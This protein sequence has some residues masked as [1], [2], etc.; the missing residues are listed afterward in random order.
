MSLREDERSDFNHAIIGPLDSI[1]LKLFGVW[2]LFLSP[3]GRKRVVSAPSE[4]RRCGRLCCGGGFG[5]APALVT[6]ADLLS[7]KL[8]SAVL[9]WCRDLPLGCCC[10][11]DWDRA[12]L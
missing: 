5:F 8:R 7:E 10:A 4:L 1:F 2:S 12:P 6:I 11:G 3:P 9:L